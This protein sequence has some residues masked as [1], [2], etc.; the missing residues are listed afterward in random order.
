M[1]FKLGKKPALPWRAS[2]NTFRFRTYADMT[3]LPAVPQR[4]SEVRC[5]G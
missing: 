2:G 5:R 4:S 1:T 3:A